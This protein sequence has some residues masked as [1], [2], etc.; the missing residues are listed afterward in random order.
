MIIL[1]AFSF[2][3]S[4]HNLF[5]I[6]FHRY[7]EYGKSPSPTS[8]VGSGSGC[9]S[10]SSFES[11]VPD[12]ATV[13]DHDATS[14]PPVP[15][16]APAPCPPQPLTGQQDYTGV[17]NMAIAQA[18]PGIMGHHPLYTPYSTEQSLGQWNGPPST[19]YPPPP[20]PPHH[21]LPAEYSSQA[22]HH[23]YHHG[24]VGD[25]SQYPLFSYSCWWVD[26]ELKCR[27]KTEWG[28]SV[29]FFSPPPGRWRRVP[30]STRWTVEHWVNVMRSW[31]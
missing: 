25:W 6:S 9:V 20:P 10:R 12:V 24:N 5:P 21:H 27:V 26:E 8:S 15:E 30:T 17:L 18:K 11:R 2:V 22:V 3:T 1:I 29:W 19:Q 23:S 13:P 14:K 31:H 28:T 7:Q 4:T 16:F